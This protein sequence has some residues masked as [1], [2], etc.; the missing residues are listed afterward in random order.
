MANELSRNNSFFPD[1]F[2][3]WSNNF[4]GTNNTFKTDI[5]END[6]GYTVTSE[7]PG[8]KKDNLNIDYENDILTISAS[9]N[10]EDEEKNENGDLIHSERSFGQTSRQ[11]YL[12]D[13][14]QSKITAKYDGG[15]LTI[16]VPKLA[17]DQSGHH[18]IEIN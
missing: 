15:V 14:D 1:F 13:G 7:L 9:R 3:D 17:P 11:F 5:A 6:D 12:K 4:F 10:K 2:N 18:N 16:D 8:F